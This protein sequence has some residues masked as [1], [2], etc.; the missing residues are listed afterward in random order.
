M[1][2]LYEVLCGCF[3]SPQGN[4]VQD[5]GDHYQDSGSHHPPSNGILNGEII[6]QVHPVTHLK[7][8]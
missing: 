2:K 7:E 6:S 1:M 4:S 5:K 8:L 3:G